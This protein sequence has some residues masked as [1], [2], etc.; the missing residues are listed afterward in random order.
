MQKF[1]QF[2]NQRLQE[3]KLPDFIIDVQNIPGIKVDNIKETSKTTT[4][5][6]V[7]KDR[8]STLEKINNI[9]KKI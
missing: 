6:I 2:H 4:I 5:K 8:Y 1:K 9:L 7:S 3:E